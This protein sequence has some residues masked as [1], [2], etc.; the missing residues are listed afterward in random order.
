MEDRLDLERLV[1]GLRPWHVVAYPAYPSGDASAG[2]PND[3]PYAAHSRSSAAA[4]RAGSVR[5]GG[6]KW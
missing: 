2:H 1:V 6:S 5:W 3:W 4:T